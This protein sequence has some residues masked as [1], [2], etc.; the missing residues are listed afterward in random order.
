MLHFVVVSSHQLLY[1]SLHAFLCK[2]VCLFV[3]R[4]AGHVDI[5]YF[6]GLYSPYL[7][8]KS[9]S[10]TRRRFQSQSFAFLVA[11]VI[12]GK[13]TDESL[14]CYSTLLE[15]HRMFL[16]CC[17][18]GELGGI[19]EHKWKSGE[20]LTN[21]VPNSNSWEIQDSLPNH[22]GT[23]SPKISNYL[24][25]SCLNS[26][27]QARTTAIPPSPRPRNSPLQHEKRVELSFSTFGRLRK[28]F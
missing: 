16:L 4:N 3:S 26:R 6:S 10:D 8:R 7:T 21:C 24:V 18:L 22:L 12:T 27:G 20:T 15:S 23:R 2:V 9:R 28:A 1:I 19:W 14:P 13:H 11:D 17:V 5:N 25:S